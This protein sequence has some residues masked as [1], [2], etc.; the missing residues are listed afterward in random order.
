MT[1]VTFE[2]FENL[3]GGHGSDRFTYGRSGKP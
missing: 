2:S 1:A 3:E